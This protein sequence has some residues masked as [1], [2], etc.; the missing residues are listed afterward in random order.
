MNGELLVALA[1]NA[2][3]LWALLILVHLASAG[4]E[5]E[6]RL[7][8]AGLGAMIGAAAIALVLTGYQTPAGMLYDTRTVL[9][10]L[11]GLLFSPLATAIAAA[12]AIAHRIQ[13]AGPV[14]GAG[15]MALLVAGGLGMA[16]RSVL[17]RPLTN[18]S[19]LHLYALGMLIHALILLIPPLLSLQP[20]ATGLPVETLPVL[21]FY[22]PVL[23]CGGKLILWLRELE[24]TGKRVA[25]Q[26]HQLE[27]LADLGRAGLGDHDLRSHRLTLSPQMARQFRL[28]SS[29]RNVPVE[30]LMEQAHTLDRERLEQE[31][32]LMVERAT[33]ARPAE[34]S[35]DYRLKR[36]ENEWE[37]MRC[38][39]RV[40]DWDREG[41]PTRILMAQTS[42]DEQRRLQESRRKLQR[43][44]DSMMTEASQSRL[45][46]LSVLE[47]R[48]K[49]EQALRES[50]RLLDEMSHLARII[51]WEKDLTTNE[52]RFTPGIYRMAEQPGS[53]EITFQ[54][55]DALMHPE[56][57][58]RI[59]QAVRE[60]LA[61]KHKSIDQELRF[62]H[63][64]GAISWAHSVGAVVWE[65]DRPIRLRGSLQD[66]TPIKEAEAERRK[67]Y[68]MLVKM[69]AQVPGAIFQYQRSPD[70]DGF[71]P[72]ASEGMRQI[73]ELEPE[74][75]REDAG[76]AFSRVHPDDLARL[77]QG[78][79]ESERNP[80]ASNAGWYCPNRVCN[81]VVAI[82]S[83][84]GRKTAPPCG[85][86]FLPT[87]RNAKRWKSGCSCRAWSTNTAARR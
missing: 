1:Q 42:I 70:S 58:V 65:N 48:K 37:W 3:V 72:W 78:I 5:G 19:W 10:A 81:G 7:R 60:C 62:V 2:A 21:L 15:I 61:D 47:D 59:A 29:Q 18:L 40:V 73:L 43:E 86:A 80:C 51:G 53:S 71:F 32:Q 74:A 41:R 45:A 57:R 85:T 76:A 17:P 36:G 12:V 77:R 75:V 63:P 56:D 44:A 4:G 50:Q 6:S 52:K 22:P 83:R 20:D 69:A 38:L 55:G 64:D 24:A 54:Q 35:V 14:V 46:L 66:I 27:L 87:S 9:L 30:T 84:S 26:D 13:V 11:A 82:P 16:A 31:I 25:N 34:L 33:P 8:Q 79:A 67:S 39:S 23:A 49:T 68:D 28:D